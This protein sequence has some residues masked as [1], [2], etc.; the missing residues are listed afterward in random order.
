MSD[1]CGGRLLLLASAVRVASVAVYKYRRPPRQ[2]QTNRL[3]R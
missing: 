2:T 3:L 1:R